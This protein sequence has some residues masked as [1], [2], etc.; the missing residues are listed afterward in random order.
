MRVKKLR[1]VLGAVTAAAMLVVFCNRRIAIYE[2]ITL[3]VLEVQDIVLMP[4]DCLKQEMYIPYDYLEKISIAFAYQEEKSQD[5]EAL[6]EVIADGEAVMSQ[7]LHVS[8]CPNYGFLDYYVDLDKCEG[9]TVTISVS[10]VSP[11]TA[12]NGE[13]GLMSTDKEFLFPDMVST[14]RIN[15]MDTD[16][17]IFC[18]AVCVKGY[19]YYESV[20]G[21]FLILLAGGVILERLTGR[22]QDRQ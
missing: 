12:S 15:D 22:R 20:T 10:N 8:A 13:F 11:E 14:C 21:A 2:D 4:G 16:S 9:K 1:I 3:N 18:R 19:S 6:V 5:A 7:E 17:C